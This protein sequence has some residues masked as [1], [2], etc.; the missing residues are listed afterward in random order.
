MAYR[1]SSE[2]I[3][4]K[5]GKKNCPRFETRIFWLSISDALSTE[6]RFPSVLYSIISSYYDVLCYIVDHCISL[7]C[8]VYAGETEK[9]WRLQLHDDSH[10]EGEET[11]KVRLTDVVMTTTE[12]PDVAIVTITDEE[13]GTLFF[14]QEL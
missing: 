9:V 7:Y 11:F 12:H 13:D 2:S 4:A 6:V 5:W 14:A 1:I 8:I 3:Y 10:Y